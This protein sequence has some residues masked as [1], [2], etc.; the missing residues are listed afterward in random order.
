MK[1]SFRAFITFLAFLTFL[2]IPLF[3]LSPAFAL[4]KKSGDI[5][6]VTDEPLFPSSII[7]Y[8]G[9]KIEKSI[10]VKNRGSGPK[11]IEIEA[12]S[13]LVSK[14][15]VDVLQFEVKEGTKTLYGGAPLKTLKNFFE[16]Q[17]LELSEIW[18][19]DDGRSYVLI[20][21]MPLTAG[22]EYQGGK[23]SFDLRVGFPG[24]A[25]SSVI[26]SSNTATSTNVSTTSTTLP[27]SVPLIKSTSQVLGESVSPTPA[28]SSID[29]T[30]RGNFESGENQFP[31]NRFIIIIGL[32]I[33]GILVLAF[34]FRPRRP[35]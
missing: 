28:I 25:S 30:S 17:T 35:S 15:L 26:I 4:V 8:P 22:N 20:V 21:S 23:V 18:V 11:K 16:A 33:S 27:I 19:N 12:M 2:T 14:N 24:D 31:R 9:L 6:I 13:E 32:L 3:S 29:E 34:V 5:E 1:N 10:Q 7:W